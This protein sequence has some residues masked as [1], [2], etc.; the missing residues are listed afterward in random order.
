MRVP[1]EALADQ[2]REEVGLGAPARAAGREGL[3]HPQ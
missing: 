1:R 3:R 2:A